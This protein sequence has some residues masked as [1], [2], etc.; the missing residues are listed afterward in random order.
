VMLIE[1]V[2]GRR[3]LAG[4]ETQTIRV[5]DWDTASRTQRRSCPRW[6]GSVHRSR[7][8]R[9]GWRDLRTPSPERRGRDQSCR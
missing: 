6:S 8:S 2:R 3:N 1:A 9:C 4:N 7:N 5:T